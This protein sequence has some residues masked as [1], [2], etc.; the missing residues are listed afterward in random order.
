MIRRFVPVTTNFYQSYFIKRAGAGVCAGG[1]HIEHGDQDRHVLVL[2][3]A[4]G[5][6]L[7]AVGDV[8][9]SV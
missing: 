8:A 6:K 7:L 1:G 4:G 2:Q 5:G 9:G 3:T